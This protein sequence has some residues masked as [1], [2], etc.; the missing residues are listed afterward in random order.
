[1]L[2]SAV[3]LSDAYGL[4]ANSTPEE[5]SGPSGMS[6]PLCRIANRE[7]DAPTENRHNFVFERQFSQLGQSV[8][9]F[10][11]VSCSVQMIKV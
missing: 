1:M 5:Q 6:I 10:K 11:D 3:S 7:G 2:Y 8:C 9:A 4:H